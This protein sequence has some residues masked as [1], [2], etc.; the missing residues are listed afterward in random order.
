MYIKYIILYILYI[1]IL[2]I[3]YEFQPCWECDW[4]PNHTL[5][6]GLD[7]QDINMTCDPT[8]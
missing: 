7:L 2:Y 4:K 8:S 3:Y 5:G 6:T 1:H